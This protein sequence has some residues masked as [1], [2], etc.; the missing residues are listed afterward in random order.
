[1]KKIFTLSAL[2]FASA[3]FL[4]GCIKT[5]YPYYDQSYWLSK[6]RGEVVYSGT[7]CNYYVIETYYGFTIVRGWGSYKPLERSIVY[8]DFS[9]TGTKEMYNRTTG[10]VFTGTITDTRLTYLEAQE[11]LDYYCPLGGKNQT[12]E[13]VKTGQ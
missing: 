2:I 12:R 3:F 5:D 10:T 4:S 9:Y 13:F 1:M 8:G 6:E 11:I 7:Y